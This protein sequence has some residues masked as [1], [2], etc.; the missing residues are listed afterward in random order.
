VAEVP[1]TYVERRE[2]QSKMSRG[3]ILESAITPWRLIASRKSARPTD[4]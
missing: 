1:I 3:V 2:G 4:R